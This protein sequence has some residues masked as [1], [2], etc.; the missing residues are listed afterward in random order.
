MKRKTIIIAEAGVNHNKNIS[1]AKKLISKA[2]I[3][4]ADYIKFQF[5]DP[6]LVVKKNTSLAEYQ[7]KNSNF[8]NQFDLLK[9]LSLSEKQIDTIYNFCK[10]KKNRFSLFSF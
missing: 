7:K 4:G 9:N 8:N 10:K 1:I 6:E 2:A 3:L 5:F